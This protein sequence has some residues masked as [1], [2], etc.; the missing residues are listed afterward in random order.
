MRVLI[1]GDIE[2][3]SG[4]VKPQQGNGAEKIYQEARRLYTEEFNA[5]IRGAAAAG[6][7]EIV[8]LDCHG[9]GGP[10]T[11]NSLV[12]DLLDERCDWVVQNRWTEY[13]GFLEEGCDAALLIGMHAMAGAA[14]GVLSHTVSGTDWH[15]LRFNGKPAGETAINAALC[16]TWGCPV[17]MVSGDDVVCDEARDLLGPEL[18]TVVAKEGLGRYSARNYGV[19]R[20]RRLIEEGAERALSDP[21]A[22][23]PYVPEKPCTIE[24]T[25]RTADR[26]EKFRHI[27]WIEIIDGRNILVRADD[28]WSAW[29]SFYFIE[30]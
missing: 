27:P 2:G 25:Y 14:R 16:G 1:I 4:V 10:W 18:T 20:V 30:A 21:S 3:V 28:W 11:F 24:V 6:A 22:I 19:K 17:V 26:A 29:R 13:T 8:A 15:E 7:D 23:D 9:A 12:P 5:A